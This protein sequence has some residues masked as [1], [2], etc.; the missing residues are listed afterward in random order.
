MRFIV[1]AAGM[2]LLTVTAPLFAVESPQV[3][4]PRLKIELVAAEP[5]IVT[6]TG[7]A[8]DE[9]GRIWCIEN[10]TH[11]RTADYKGPPTDRIRIY[12]DFDE[13]GKA[14]KVRTFAEG[15]KNSMSLAVRPGGEIFL[16]ERSAIYRIREKDGKEIERKVIVKLDTKG[17]YPHNGLS[18][19][20]FDADG[21]MYFGMGENLGEPYTLVGS[22]KSGWAG[23]GEGGNIFRC[24]PDGSKIERIATG[25]WNPFGM[26]FDLHGRMFAVDNDPDSR[27]PCRL[28][29]VIQ[30]GDY[31]YRY[32]YGRK[33]LHPFQSWNGELPGTLPMVAGTSEAPS[34]IL[35]CPFAGW[36]KEYQGALFST[37]WGDHVIETFDPKPKGASFTAMAKILV[38]GNENFRPVSIV[39]CPDGSLVF[40][41]WVDKSYP[42]HGK[43]RIWRLRLKTPLP[44]PAPRIGSLPENNK[45]LVRLNSI[46]LIDDTKR[47]KKEVAPLLASSDPFIV[48]A[49]ISALRIVTLD[50]ITRLSPDSRMRLGALLLTR[51][52]AGHLETHPE[53][54][55][56]IRS[57][58]PE[59][60][61][62]TD[63]EVRR[64]AI[65]WVAEGRLKE[66]TPLLES[67]ASKPP[68]TR[69]LFEA[70]LAA[71]DLLS[72][73][74][75]AWKDE[76]PGEEYVSAIVK[77]S[78]Q[79]VMFRLL[80]LRMLRPD[81]PVLTPALLRSYLSEPD[82]GLRHEALRTLI[83]RPDAEAQEMLRK[84]ADDDTNP[85][86]LRALAVVGLALSAKNFET[87]RLLHKLRKQPFLQ[88]EVL[89]TLG[90][91]RILEPRHS[92]AEWQKLLEEKGDAVTGE[93]VFFHPN[94][95][96]CYKC[97]KIDGR[98]AGIGPDLS[99]IASSMSRE[100]II[101]SILEP[102]KEIAPAFTTW[103]ILTRDGK[104]RTG[105]IVGEDAF[106]YVTVADSQ[107]KIE[108]I[109]R[110]EIEDRTA[111]P[112][113]IMPENL[114][115]LMTRQDFRD[116]LA[117]LLE[118]K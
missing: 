16:A 75:R 8:V 95:P 39:A 48:S 13:N 51:R 63:P 66:L 25:F 64:T 65:Q 42:V 89:R 100:K 50:G 49:A 14:R 46:L 107:G 10:H 34:G 43:G 84:F 82:E 58:L 1:S 112:K 88:D 6:P 102:S 70:Y 35:A 108:K 24:Q 60:L 101:E 18:D 26:C 81:H 98:G 106:S 21:N 110:R 5:D 2:F 99:R 111:L 17:D 45:E 117:F 28:L 33:G 74:P 30:G 56:V 47:L 72:E 104:E 80:A 96:G 91:R 9:Q 83:E 41:D 85:S 27:G 113:S 73:H 69:E 115:E 59:Y 37:S 105:M 12:E 61:A 78:K 53:I 7:L 62:D 116:L 79:P 86:Q 11:Q 23:G 67:A 55:Q 31:G 77:D 40:N 90:E 71:R 103:R 38:R 54:R 22:D 4:D 118:R 36:P 15:F 92:P 3:L 93:R 32:R 114:P 109:H 57:I 87:D 76:A 97:H 52:D 68:V 44:Y 20:A 29:H 19:I 94:G